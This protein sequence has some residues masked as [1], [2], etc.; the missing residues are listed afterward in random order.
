MLCADHIAW[1]S[2]PLARGL[3][4]TDFSDLIAARI[5]PARAGFTW[6]CNRD[7]K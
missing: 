3:L 1:G 7:R 5:I 2:S 4:M 6:G